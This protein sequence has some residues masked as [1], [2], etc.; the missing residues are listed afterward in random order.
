MTRRSRWQRLCCR[1]GRHGKVVAGDAKEEF[2]FDEARGLSV[3]LRMTF[4]H[5]CGH[6]TSEATWLRTPTPGEKAQQSQVVAHDRLDV[7]VLKKLAAAEVQ[8]LHLSLLQA[9]LELPTEEALLRHLEY[10]HLRGLV[11]IEAKTG[12]IAPTQRGLARLKG[13]APTLYTYATSVMACPRCNSHMILHFP[14]D[15][16]TCSACNYSADERSVRNSGSRD[17]LDWDRPVNRRPNR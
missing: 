15:K 16:V 14:G 9:A 1:L 10:M 3:L 6:E 12:L 8:M 17:P 5:A 11:F 13:E 2:T 7:I 4:K